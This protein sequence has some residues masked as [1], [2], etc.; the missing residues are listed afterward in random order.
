M[1]NIIIMGFSF[2]E[3]S[4]MFFF[5]SIVGWFLEVVVRSLE[6]G[7]FES[8]GMLSGPYCPIYGFGVIFVV[9]A[10]NPIVD[11]ALILFLLS[12][13]ICTALELFVGIMLEKL[14]DTQWWNYSDYKH[15][16]KGY[17]ALKISLLWGAG[18][19]IVVRIAHPAIMKM[20]S[21]IPTNAGSA[22][23]LVLYVLIFIDT[24][25]TISSLLKFKRKLY[26]LE[27]LHEKIFKTT[28][29]VGTNISGEIVGIKCKYDKVIETT[30]E[31]SAAIVEST[32]GKLGGTK[33]KAA[34][35]TDDFSELFQ[36]YENLLEITR[37]KSERFLSAFPNLTSHTRKN[38]LNAVKERFN[39]VKIKK[40]K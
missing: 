1:R 36:K 28:N 23:I 31:K 20:I 35:Q 5:W 11:N 24:Y 8:R 34:K 4:F 37:K 13:V 3:L 15:N 29:A 12:A 22:I 25:Q 18:C 33:G 17:I 9:I 40:K 30:K 10:S 19:L 16:Y 14:F 26:Q 2:F 39:K 27:K 6:T 7:L 38:A 21:W 32:K